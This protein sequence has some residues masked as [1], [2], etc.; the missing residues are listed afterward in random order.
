MVNWERERVKKN[1]R[2]IDLEKENKIPKCPNCYYRKREE[3]LGLTRGWNV[4]KNGD[5]CG[6]FLKEGS[7]FQIL[8]EP[9]RYNAKEN[10]REVFKQLGP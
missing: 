5:H 1:G 4:A 8:K 2:K 3:G 7:C 6:F 10:W 9:D